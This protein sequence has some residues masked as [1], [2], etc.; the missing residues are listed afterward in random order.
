MKVLYS[1]GKADGVMEW[2]NDSPVIMGLHVPFEDKSPS[3]CKLSLLLKSP[4]VLGE[5]ETKSLMPSTPANGKITPRIHRA[6]A[7]SEFIA[8]PDQTLP[9]PPWQKYSCSLDNCIVVG[10]ITIQWMTYRCYNIEIGQAWAFEVLRDWHKTVTSGKDG[11]ILPWHRWSKDELQGIRDKI[12]AKLQSDFAVT[13][14]S[15]SS[16]SHVEDFIFPESL[17]MWRYV[18]N[19]KCQ[20]GSKEEDVE[21]KDLSVYIPDNLQSR[22]MQEILDQHVYFHPQSDVNPFG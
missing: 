5:I 10:I 19:L 1:C 4:V 20:C 8:S 17:R 14:D 15:K 16:I 6:F 7:D 12:R 21:R 18:R 22:N 11:A 3:T 13:V 2:G 9:G